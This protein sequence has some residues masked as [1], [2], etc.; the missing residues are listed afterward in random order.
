MQYIDFIIKNLLRGIFIFSIPFFQNLDYTKKED[1]ISEGWFMKSGKPEESKRQTVEGEI[2]IKLSEIDNPAHLYIDEAGIVHLQ[3]P[4]VGA[5]DGLATDNTCKSLT[6][7]K[8]FFDP[9]KGALSQL[10]RYQSTLEA[11]IAILS[12]DQAKNED[13]INKKKSRLEQVQVYYPALQAMTAD[14]AKTADF[15]PVF[16]VFPD[17]IKEVLAK[18][19]NVYGMRLRPDIEDPYSRLP[20][21]AIFNVN[22]N[23]KDENDSQVGKE[24]ILFDRLNSAYETISNVPGSGGVHSEALAKWEQS[25]KVHL[26]SDAGADVRGRLIG[27]ID[28]YKA[29]N[30]ALKDLE[31]KTTGS[32]SRKMKSIDTELNGLQPP[33]SESEEERAIRAQKKQ[34]LMAERAELEAKRKGAEATIKP[35][36]EEFVRQQKASMQLFEQE[37]ILVLRGQYYAHFSVPGGQETLVERFWRDKQNPDEAI[38]RSLM[39]ATQGDDS[40]EEILATLTDPAL[41]GLAEQPGLLPTNPGY[42]PFRWTADLSDKKNRNKLN[43]ITQF[44]LAEINIEIA[45][46][47][48][49]VRDF[50]QIL[51]GNQTLM[52]PLADCIKMALENDNQSVEAAICG[53]FNSNKAAFEFET[54]LSES[55][56]QRITG[57]FQKHVDCIKDHAELDEFLLL[58][59]EKDSLCSMHQNAIRFDFAHLMNTERFRH[60]DTEQFAELRSLP[61]KSVL[62]PR[63][64]LDGTTTVSLSSIE[65]IISGSDEKKIDQILSSPAIAAWLLEKQAPRLPTLLKKP[66]STVIAQEIILLIPTAG[67]VFGDDQEK[68]AAL[69]AALI[70]KWERIIKLSDSRSLSVEKAKLVMAVKRA[71]VCLAK[72]YMSPEAYCAAYLTPFASRAKQIYQDLV[73]QRDQNA[74]SE[75]LLQEIQEALAGMSFSSE[76]DR[77][78]FSEFIDIIALGEPLKIA[79]RYDYDAWSEILERMERGPWKETLSQLPQI[80]EEK[81]RSEVARINA[82]AAVQAPMSPER[83]KDI[84]FSKEK[85]DTSNLRQ[86]ALAIDNRATFLGGLD[87]MSLEAKSILSEASACLRSSCAAQLMDRITAMNI[88]PATITEADAIEIM[89]LGAHPEEAAK[90]NVSSLDAVAS[91]VLQMARVAKEDPRYT[92]VNRILSQAHETLSEKW[93]TPAKHAKHFLEPRIFRLQDK[94]LAATIGEESFLEGKESQVRNAIQRIAPGEDGRALREMAALLFADTPLTREAIIEKGGAYWKEQEAR[95]EEWLGRLNAKCSVLAETVRQRQQEFARYPLESHSNK[96]LSFLRLYDEDQRISTNPKLP[97]LLLSV[98]E[99]LQHFD[100][101]KHER[102]ELFASF[103]K[104][105]T[106]K[107]EKGKVEDL[108]GVKDVMSTLGLTFNLNNVH[109]GA[110]LLE[111]K[112]KSLEKHGLTDTDE[113]RLIS[114]AQFFLASYGLCDDEELEEAPKDDERTPVIPVDNE[115]E[116]VESDFDDELE[117]SNP[118]ANA[119]EP[120]SD[121]ILVEKP[122]AEEIKADVIASLSEL[123]KNISYADEVNICITAIQTEDLSKGLEGLKALE[124]YIKKAKGGLFKQG[125]TAN[126]LT[127]LSRLKTLVNQTLPEPEVQHGN[128]LRP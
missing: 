112:K 118:L 15:S 71:Q 3:V 76:S 65:E 48:S 20:I 87:G 18:S 9:E 17:C 7:L 1:A 45:S 88:N 38:V 123:R 122:T 47:Q 120:D 121:W 21:S 53:W 128:R 73:K 127:I 96:L 98:E 36:K 94:I 91:Q 10:K 117:A 43:V 66:M 80:M 8:Q 90:L 59:T 75:Y 79:Q 12:I 60:L 46:R 100:R 4:I 2:S 104:L 62:P 25:V 109:D 125:S 126:A 42:S 74:S 83:A 67:K 86:G 55:D 92:T 33:L 61:A 110:D 35:Q 78:E 13:E 49:G 58:N 89:K 28:Q 27:F 69:L 29:Q 108:N 113:Y 77:K 84:L 97:Q 101:L 106:L 82:L 34:T 51:E 111:D 16:P 107:L 81:R 32:L 22:R 14:F 72:E 40:S 102:E 116:P 93:N 95:W 52:Q 41:Y 50:G 24:S 23:R 5:S 115:I 44:F 26:D 119:A 57:K 37:L 19:S 114:S 56:I 99:G 105:Q 6:A 68:N 39:E 85:W 54:V 31:E 63:G 11:D 64:P 124:E 103:S 70:E 30:A